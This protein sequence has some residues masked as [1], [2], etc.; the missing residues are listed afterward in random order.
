[1]FFFTTYNK[2]GYLIS[3]VIIV[4][5]IKSAAP[6][7]MEACVLEPNYLSARGAPVR[8]EYEKAL[9]CRYIIPRLV[10]KPERGR[11]HSS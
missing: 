2:Q 10:S 4:A 1:M 3:T 5:L 9:L 6:G 11:L 7:V 8:R